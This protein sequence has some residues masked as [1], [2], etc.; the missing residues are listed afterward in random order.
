MPTR[1][2]RGSARARTVAA[3]ARAR[4]AAAPTH[5]QRTKV[6]IVDD[7]TIVRQGL[8]ALLGSKPDMEIVGEAADGPEAIRK[9]EACKPDVVVLDLSMP[10]LSGSETATRLLRSRPAV[11]ILALTMHDGEDHI[12]ALL[13][14]G[15]RGFLLKESASADLVQAIRAVVDGGI[16]LHPRISSKVVAEYLKRPHPSARKA[17]QD[18]LTPRETQILRLIAE[19]HTNREIAYLL[20]ISVK[21]VEAHRT[22]IMEKLEIHNVA[23]LTRYAIRRGITGVEGP[24]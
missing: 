3:P 4:T 15:A 23:G 16:Y 18:G 7:H 8:C 11:R 17:G 2:G 20:V 9:A 5:V 10:G 21:T 6:M 12:Y 13:K 19:A 1:S 14:A 24:S 22:R